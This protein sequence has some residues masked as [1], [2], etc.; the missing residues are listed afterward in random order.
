MVHWPLPPTIFLPVWGGRF[1][2]PMRCEAAAPARESRIERLIG[3]FAAR[4]SVAGDDLR[5]SVEAFGGGGA[6]GIMMCRA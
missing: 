2:H 6:L 4:V 1:V 3:H 5:H